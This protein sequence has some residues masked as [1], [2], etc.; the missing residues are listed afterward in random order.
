MNSAASRRVVITGMGLVSPLGN[1]LAGLWEALVARRSGVGPLQ[2][3]PPNGVPTQV[4][5]EARQFVGDV[6]EFGPLDKERKKTIKKAMKVMCRESQMAIVAA[7]L[8]LTDAGLRPESTDPERA[9]CVFGSDYMLTEPQELA[10]GILKC[11]GRE[12]AFEFS[13]WGVEGLEQMTP[14]WML[15]YLPNM[16]ASHI[17]ILND[18]RGPSNSI[19]HREA[20]SNLALG[21]AYHTIARGSADR[22]VAGA[23]GTRV[24]PMKAVHA[25]QSEQLAV[26]NGDPTKASRPFDRHR[27]GMVLGEGA[28][29]VILEELET[30]RARGARI[31][32]EVVGAAS[33]SVADRNRVAQRDVALANAMRSAMRQS[34]G[35][36][37][38]ATVNAADVEMG[39][40]N[41]HGLS[42]L[43][44]DAD[45]Y[46]AL[47]AVFGERADQIPVVAPKSYFGNL[48][49]AS[50]LVELIASMLAMQEGRLF[51]ILNYETPDPDC[52]ILAVQDD[53]TPPGDSFLNLSVTPQGQAAVVMVRAI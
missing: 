48:G 14:L 20:S 8:A 33:S 45:E 35:I 15:K 24:H 18:L 46:R 28:A 52:P 16:P 39:H 36:K 37:N 12:G 38:G 19:T 51:P 41:A 10:E 4:S 25:A 6:D 31:Y 44:S 9:G 27:S 47:Q 50:G 43:T 3:V 22:M 40:I 49:A 30:A 5:A 26:G 11:G 32:G 29:S 21:E 7:H 53:A 2:S 1:S 13:R 34:L 17:A 42:T 23:T